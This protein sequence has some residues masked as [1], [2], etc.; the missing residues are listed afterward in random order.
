MEHQKILKK[1]QNTKL[2]D[3]EEKKELER[4]AQKFFK[5]DGQ[6]SS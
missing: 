1:L 2:L 6:F 4:K 3:E 5:I